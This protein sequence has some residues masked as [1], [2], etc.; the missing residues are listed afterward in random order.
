MRVCYL[1]A[2]ALLLAV[3]SPQA[4]AQQCDEEVLFETAA[5]VITVRHIETLYNCCCTV[6]CEVLQDAFTL[7]V[8]E[9]EY[10]IAGGC[11]C[12]C[13]SDVTVEIGGLEPGEYTVNIIK[14]T[15]HGGEEHVGTWSVIV[16]G[17]SPPSLRTTYAP[18][19]ETG[20]IDEST[21][22]VIKAL[23]R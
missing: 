14:H 16:Y 12:L 15:E 3:V 20:T 6:E 19:G 5:G 23:Y 22:S 1:L 2:A 10:L 9:Y 13:C 7:D 21:W 11:D 4:V 18:C 17:T 8:H